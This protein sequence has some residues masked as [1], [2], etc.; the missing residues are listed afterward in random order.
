MEL[1]RYPIALIASPFAASLVLF[2]LWYGAK[3]RRDLL[4]KIGSADLL[5]RLIPKET[6]ALRKVKGWL[7]A[8]AVFFLALAVSGPQWGVELTASDS[9]VT[10]VM[11]AIDTSLSMLA[12]DIKPSRIEDAK[13]ML[14]ILVDQLA[15][16]RIGVVGFS[17]KA[18]LQCPITTD[19]D[20]IKYFVSSSVPGMYPES[21]T[22]LGDAIYLST[23]M[24]A[25][26]P[27]QKALVL[28]TDGEDRK[29]ELKEALKVAKEQGITIFTVGIG[30]P[31]GDLIPLP[32]APGQSGQ[33]DFKKDKNGNPVMTRLG[34][35]TLIDIAQQTGGAYFRYTEPESVASAIAKQ[36]QGFEKGKWKSRGRA[37]FKNRYQ[38]PLFIALLLLLLELLVPERKSEALAALERSLPAKQ[39]ARGG[40]K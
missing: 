30:K 6:E 4:N 37:T 20:A 28:L 14:N 38:Y 33:R 25:P 3:K 24:L 2:L 22:N 35:K 13:L 18:Y 40:G 9:S 12:Q 29:D 15:G 36:V 16:S 27:G 23:R 7:L 11:I 39:A 32:L 5:L 8:G 31:E 1:F 19:Q 17:G 34:E 26:Y 21:G 10:H